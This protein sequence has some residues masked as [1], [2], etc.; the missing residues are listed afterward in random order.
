MSERLFIYPNDIMIIEDC[1]Y[2]T[3]L[4][5]LR[6]IKDSF[7]KNKN[8]KVSIKTY[9]EFTDVELQDVKQMIL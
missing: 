9:C 4:R 5:R 1:S 6:A 2:S 8:Q 7:G 3:A